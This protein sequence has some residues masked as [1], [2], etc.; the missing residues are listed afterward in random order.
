MGWM[1]KQWRN[2]VIYLYA[3]IYLCPDSGMAIFKNLLFRTNLGGP[4]VV[5]AHVAGNGH[6]PY[7]V[8]IIV[9]AIKVQ[10]GLTYTNIGFES[11]LGLKGI[12]EEADIQHIACCVLGTWH[13][14]AKF[15]DKF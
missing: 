12:C 3:C 1:Q 6:H 13:F 7:F 14:F 9:N 4:N 5:T 11:I 10:F 8:S 2:D 15:V